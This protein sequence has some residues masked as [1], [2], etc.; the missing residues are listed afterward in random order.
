M[1]QQ[2]I[3]AVVRKRRAAVAAAFIAVAATTNL[4]ETRASSYFE[5]RLDF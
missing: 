4:H 2:A 5:P 1:Q 3:Q